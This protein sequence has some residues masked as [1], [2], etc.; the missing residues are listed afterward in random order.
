MLVV[1]VVVVVV[2]VVRD[3]ESME[4]DG[5]KMCPLIYLFCVSTSCLGGWSVKP[6]TVRL[7]NTRLE[8]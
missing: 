2:V 1:I 4:N 7:G 8:V 5:V 3:C 6:F